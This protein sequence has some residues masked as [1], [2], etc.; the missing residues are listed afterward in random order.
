MVDPS[1]REAPT[2]RPATR[3][4]VLA[5]DPDHAGDTVTAAVGTLGGKIIGMGGFVH[6][7][8][9]LVAFLDLEPEA[10]PYRVALVKAARGML[11]SMGASGKAIFATPDPDIPG[12]VRF[13]TALGFKPF[14]GRPGLFIWQG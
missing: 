3:D 10:A 13:M 9:I 12:A 1:K 11:R 6:K 8:G 14:A 5:Y 2:I 7:S 4:D